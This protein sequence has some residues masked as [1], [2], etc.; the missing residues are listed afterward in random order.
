MTRQSDRIQHNTDEAVR[1]FRP[2]TASVAKDLSMPRGVLKVIAGLTLGI[3]LCAPLTQAQDFD[4]TGDGGDIQVP[5]PPPTPPSKC[6]GYC[7]NG[8]INPGY[9]AWAH[10]QAAQ[11]AEQ[12]REYD[13]RMYRQDVAQSDTIFHRSHDAET[14]HDYALAISLDE[15]KLAY[16]KQA[17]YANF[18]LAQD[19]ANIDIDKAN[20]AWSEGNY[21][22]ALAYMNQVDDKYL[23]AQNRQ[24]IAGLQRLVEKQREMA[25][26]QQESTAFVAQENTEMERQARENAAQ[27][28][29]MLAQRATA[30]LQDF[31]ENGDKLTPDVKALMLSQSSDGTRAFGIKS[32]S[33]NPGLEAA[34]A[35]HVGDANALN[36]A[37]RMNGSSRAGVGGASDEEAAAKADV[38]PSS[39]GG[40]ASTEG[41][42]VPPTPGATLV[43]PDVVL[44]NKDYQAANA[45]L[46]GDQAK[47]DAIQHT[48]DALQVQQAVAQT[49]AD[50]SALQ[51]KIYQMSGDL[52]QAKGQ[53]KLD[54]N[55][56]ADT[57][58][59]IEEGSPIMIGP[60]PAKSAKPASKEDKR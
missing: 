31:A 26:A 27:E 48:I 24:F 21:A 56:V 11:R 51:I 30:K 44:Q 16:D 20:L 53:V 10:Q 58:T 39:G 7:G 8:N 46:Q 49:A 52:N 2:P 3:T 35:V 37:E 6:V 4:G 22:A 13:S 12:Q 40:T 5:P 28:D 15:Q 42:G 59:S 17:R 47:L 54:Q 60:K 57:V 19:R 23:G 25:L 36:Q 34:D 50:Q 18:D 14:N 1:P 55:N 9:A 43:L 29:A 32:N 45:K 33:G 41:T 38:T